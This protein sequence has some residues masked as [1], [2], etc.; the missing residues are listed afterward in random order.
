MKN[1]LPD[2]GSGEERKNNTLETCVS[3]EEWWRVRDLNPRSIS[4]LIYS[5][6]PLATR[7]TR[8]A[9][10]NAETDYQIGCLNRK[11]SVRHPG[12]E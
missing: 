2:W 12:G 5:Q 10:C 8:L 1:P 9:L 3:R 11:N 7:V 4:Q 6:P